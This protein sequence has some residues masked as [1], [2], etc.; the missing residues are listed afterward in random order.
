MFRCGRYDHVRDLR[1][2]AHLRRPHPRQLPWWIPVV[3]TP[4]EVARCMRSHL[5]SPPGPGVR[6][7]HQ[8]RTLGG[9][10]TTKKPNNMASTREKLAVLES[11][12]AK[13]KGKRWIVGP[14]EG[15]LCSELD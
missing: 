5:G 7:I 1:S 2:M 3:S 15:D 13:E 8:A 9:L 6:G 10:P 4:M 12:L 14:V 11:Y